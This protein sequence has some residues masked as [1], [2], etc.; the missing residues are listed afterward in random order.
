MVVRQGLAP[1]VSGAALGLLAA[2]FGARV[3][4][5]FLFEVAIHEPAVYIAAGALTTL[6]AALAC[7]VPARRIGELAPAAVLRSE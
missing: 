7:F 2:W 1:V 5:Q 4:Q 3:L 6:V